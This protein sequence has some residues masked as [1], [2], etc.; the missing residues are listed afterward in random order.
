VAVDAPVATVA[1]CWRFPVKSL[2]GAPVE[3]VEVGDLGIRGDRAWALVDPAS[4]HTLSA[5]TVP[6]LLDAFATADGD[7]DG[8]GVTIA[9]PDGTRLVAGAAGTDDALSA[10][11][12]RAVALR[13]PAPGPSSYEM[14]FDPPDDTAER[15]EI[16]SPD[17]TFLDLAALHLLTTNSLDAC[18]REHPGSVWDRRRFRPNVLATAGTSEDFPE[19][20]WVGRTVRIGGA[21]FDVLMRTVRCAMPLR[22]QPPHPDGAALA[23]DV[24]VYRAMNAQHE[25][26]LGI[27]ASVREPGPIAVGDAITLA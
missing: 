27:Y 15:F 1:E 17:G 9:L 19:D 21:S 18:A 8:D 26:H 6:A 3:R 13:R 7:G 25:N 2:Q 4:G 11:L 20:A 10:W 23:R 16:P 24:D 5:K 14:T 22:A 12:G